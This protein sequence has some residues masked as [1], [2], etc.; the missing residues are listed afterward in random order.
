MTFGRN[1]DTRGMAT[2]CDGAK[3][4][5]NPA[6]GP[7]NRGVCVRVMFAGDDELEKYFR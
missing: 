3:Q 5:R 4:G 6:N 1:T 7:P 2:G